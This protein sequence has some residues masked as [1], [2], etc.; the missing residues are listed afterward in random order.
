MSLDV[1]LRYP[2]NN[3][4][5]DDPEAPEPEEVFWGN[6]THNLNKMAEAAGLYEYLWRPEEIG[7]AKAEQLIGPLT[8]GLALLRQSPDKFKPLNPANGWGSYETLVRFVQKYLT[9]CEEHP[10]ADISVSR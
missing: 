4:F 7:V 2:V 10:D 8:T 3:L 9:A 6:I 1:Y 5:A